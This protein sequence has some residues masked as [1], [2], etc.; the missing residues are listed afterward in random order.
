MFREPIVEILFLLFRNDQR[1][2]TT[3][4]SKIFAISGYVV[5]ASKNKISARRNKYLDFQ[6]AID[7]SR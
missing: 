6:E 4:K 3:L 7:N 2:I 1:K 5:E